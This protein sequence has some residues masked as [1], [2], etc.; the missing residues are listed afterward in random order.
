MYGTSFR[1]QVFDCERQCLRCQA[2]AELEAQI[3][4]HYDLPAL[5]LASRWLYR[6]TMGPRAT[7]DW[8]HKADTS[9]ADGH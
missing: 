3:Q 8:L 9:A 2:H 6:A 1:V 5:L 4:G 7:M